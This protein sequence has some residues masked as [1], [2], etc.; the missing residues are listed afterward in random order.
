MSWV[1][2]HLV[3][4]ALAELADAT[5]QRRVWLGTG[6]ADVGSLVEAMSQLFDDSGLGDALD[7]GERSIFGRETDAALVALEAKLKRLAAGSAAPAEILA[8]DRLAEIR[9][10]ARDALFAIVRYEAEESRT[11]ET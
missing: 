9:D 5:F 4:E 6:S 10:A 1:Y 2:R 7:K 8:D 11:A 3:K